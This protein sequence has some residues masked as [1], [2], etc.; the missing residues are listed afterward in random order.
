MAY[1]LSTVTTKPVI[2]SST[3]MKL[4]ANNV[5]L[6]SLQYGLCC[7]AYILSDRCACWDYNIPFT[8][9]NIQFYANH[10]SFALCACWDYNTLILFNISH[11]YDHLLV[12]IRY[13][14][15]RSVLVE[16]AARDICVSYG[17]RPLPTPIRPDIDSFEPMRLHVYKEEHIMLLRAL[18]IYNQLLSHLIW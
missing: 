5:M 4:T 2:I 13:G 8:L 18:D 16:L 7:T 17:D 11:P 15:S 3:D 10:V 14:Q 6:G 1:V 9:T 12:C